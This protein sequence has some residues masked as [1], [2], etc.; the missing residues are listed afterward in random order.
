MRKF[1]KGGKDMKA[2]ECM[3]QDVCCVKPD[4]NVNQV[5]KLMSEKH[6]GCIPVCDDNNCICGIVTDRD[7]L[8]RA[9]ACEKDTKT[10][11]VSDIMTCNVCTCK[12]DDDMTNVETKMSQ[13]QVRRLPVCD[14]DN[15]VVGILTIGDLAQ[16]DRDL[17]KQQVCDTI[18]GICNCH[19]NK[20]AE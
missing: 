17:G 9:V 8:L 2:K 11:Q 4:T 16:H 6:V 20:N 1:L 14:Q 13:N 15:K 5:A 10:C 7:I 18:Q 3:C 12:E 19:S